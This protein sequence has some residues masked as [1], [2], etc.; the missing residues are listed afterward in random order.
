MRK[1]TWVASAFLFLSCLLA[2]AQTAFKAGD[3][4]EVSWYS[5][6]YKAQVVEVKDGNYKIRY[7]TDSSEE[8]VDNTR[9]RRT[10]QQAT[11]PNTVAQATSN[12]T[13]SLKV[14]DLVELLMGNEAKHGVI[15]GG[16]QKTDFGYSTY[17]VHLEGEKFCSNH[18][19]DT[20]YDSR[21]VQKR[22]QPNTFASFVYGEG[23]EVRTVNGTVYKGH[24]LGRDENSYEVSYSWKGAPSKEWFYNTNIRSAGGNLPNLWPDRRFKLGDRVMY[25]GLGFLVNKSFGT[26][27]SIDPVKRM[28]TLRDETGASSRE[29]LPCYNVVAPNERPGSEFFVGKWDIF[30]P[31]ATYTFIKGDY[32]YRNFSAGMKLPPLEI[33]ADETYEWTNTDN[34]IVRGVWVQ[35][36]DQPGITLLKALDGKDYTLYE[37]TEAHATSK[38]TKDEIGLSHL[39]SSTG[40]LATRVGANKSCTLLNRKL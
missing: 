6:W 18:Q 28:Y 26:V 25:N 21:F 16:L 23:V 3:Q 36:K 15:V 5:T 20:K 39:P 9:I 37:K 8:W 10:G 17:K 11:A 24:V 19:L 2:Q 33:K 27:I 29:S 7:T 30:I 34:K 14:G 35:R 31:P 1:N 40:F 12:T 38:N 22:F 4:V 32:R 13:G